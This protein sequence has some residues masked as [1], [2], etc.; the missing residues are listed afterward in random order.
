MNVLA[1]L[2]VWFIAG[3]SVVIIFC[4][5]I[6]KVVLMVVGIYAVIHWLHH[7]AREK[8]GE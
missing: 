3:A 7:R 8:V 2:S 6:A 5:Q 1:E 4:V